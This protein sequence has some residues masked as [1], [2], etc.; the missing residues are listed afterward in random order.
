MAFLP[1]E[2]FIN[3]GLGWVSCFG[4]VSEILCD[5]SSGTCWLFDFHLLRHLL[6]PYQVSSLLKPSGKWLNFTV[7]VLVKHYHYLFMSDMSCKIRIQI[8]L[9][10]RICLTIYFG[11]TLVGY[12]YNI[13]PKAHVLLKTI[14]VWL[15]M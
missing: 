14:K 8:C 1:H 9:E 2:Y 13:L 7:V 4:P 15:Y 6:V 5:T 10:R 12:N 3:T 11:N